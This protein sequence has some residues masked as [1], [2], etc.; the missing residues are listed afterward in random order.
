[1]GDVCIRMVHHCTAL[2]VAVRAE[3]LEVQRAIAKAAELVVK[4]AIKRAG[5]EDM[6]PLVGLCRVKNSL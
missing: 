5:P 1:M 3:Q 4:E 6:I 2:P